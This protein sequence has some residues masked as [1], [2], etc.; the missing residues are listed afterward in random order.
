MLCSALRKAVVG[1]FSVYRGAATSLPAETPPYLAL[2][3]WPGLFP[4]RPTAQPPPSEAFAAGQT[5]T[6]SP[7]S[8][9]SLVTARQRGERD[10][11]R[12][13]FTW[14]PLTDIITGVISITSPSLPPFSSCYPCAPPPSN[15][16]LTP[17]AL[18]IIYFS[19][20]SPLQR[21]QQHSQG[22]CQ[23]VAFWLKAFQTSS[24]GP[25]GL[26]P[27]L[28]GLPTT[29]ASLPTSKERGS[30]GVWFALGWMCVCSHMCSHTST[31]CVCVSGELT[32]TW[33]DGPWNLKPHHAV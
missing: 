14:C 25:F 12:S 3:E 9:A 31:S 29:A 11:W 27:A 6:H 5:R 17:S 20:S 2:P 22:P 19:S 32:Q 23:K 18:T 15:A 24:A 33:S 8:A 30:E 7:T 10:R 4:C 26:D 16:T 1:C 13:K 21:A 28:C